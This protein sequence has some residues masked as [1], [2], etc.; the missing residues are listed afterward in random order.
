[1]NDGLADEGCST[2][3]MR[4]AASSATVAWSSLPA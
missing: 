3:P 1:M 2:R 4:T